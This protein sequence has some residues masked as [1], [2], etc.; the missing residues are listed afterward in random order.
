MWSNLFLNS[1]RYVMIG[2]KVQNSLNV[3]C[4]G[5]TI[6]ADKDIFQYQKY[7]KVQHEL[8]GLVNKY[9]FGLLKDFLPL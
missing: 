7:I 6:S 8:Y 5:L 3:V 9:Y 2:Q 1:C 4:Y